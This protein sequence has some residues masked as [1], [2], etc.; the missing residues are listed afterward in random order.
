MF[1]N[2]QQIYQSLYTNNFLIQNTGCNNLINTPPV[3]CG[4]FTLMTR[5]LISISQIPRLLIEFTRIPFLIIYAFSFF[6]FYNSYI[7]MYII[8]ANFETLEHM[9]RESIKNVG[10]NV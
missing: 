2:F 1:F 6:F 10:A 9:S 8:S 4:D 7:L 5:L 3:V